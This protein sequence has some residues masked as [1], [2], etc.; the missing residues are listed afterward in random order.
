MTRTQKWF[1]GFGIAAAVLVTTGGAIILAIP[2]D[3]ELAQRLAGKLGD[4]LGVKVTIGALH[5][6]VLPVPMVV[7][8]NTV[9][10]R[11]QP[12]V[13]DKIT[14]YPDLATLWQK[15]LKAR[16]VELE[17]GVVPQLSL[18]GL[19]DGGAKLADDA[20][21]GDKPARFTAADIPLAHFSF[22]RVT[23]ISR[24]GVPLIYD[25]D[26]DFDGHWR[27]RT[28]QFRRPDAKPLTDL[29]LDRQGGE[30]RWKTTIRVGG[31]TV[32][33]EVQLQTRADGRMHLSGQL[34]PQGVEVSSALAAFNRRSALSGKASGKTTLWSD[35]VNA[36][37]LARSLHTQ[38]SFVMS[39]A[40]L[41]RFDLTKAIHT[42]GREHDGQ[43]P[44]DSVT[45]QLDTQNNAN[46]MVS[47]FTNIKIKSGAL[48]AS[49]QAT[50]FNREI[51]AEFAVDLVD[52][53]VGVPLK[54][55]GP[56][57]HVKVSVPGGAVVGAVIGTAVLPV[58]G[59]VI[60]ARLGAALGKLFSPATAP[61]SGL[62]AGAASPGKKP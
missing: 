27:P 41:L 40:T 15:Q 62:K 6:H 32:N 29:T 55:S 61:T 9:I 10:A 14:I 49:G 48:S 43:T 26:M 45:G 4:G 59:T 34:K 56:T 30:D 5:W 12:I 17:G 19:A 44:L 22:R 8:Q 18:R 51:E 28:A 24:R 1:A 3:E 50:L 39:S 33:G 58:V 57:N 25:G 11:P 16:D 53:V 23:W 2:S 35:G 54:L 38:T 37:E 31:G 52:G 13:L 21:P 20:T 36:D 46:G 42:L 47:D 60:G 7:L